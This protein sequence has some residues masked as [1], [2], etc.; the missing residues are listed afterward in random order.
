[1]EL[2]EDTGP[3]ARRNFGCL[4]AVA[5]LVF[6][7]SIWLLSEAN[8]WP[9]ALYFVSSLAIIAVV[10]SLFPDPISLLIGMV[11]SRESPW[12]GLREFEVHVDNSEE[13]PVVVMAANSK[14]AAARW[15]AKMSLSAPTLERRQH[16]RM[17]LVDGT[18][19]SFMLHFKRDGSF[20]TTPC[21]APRARP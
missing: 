16:I 4:V 8:G 20:E 19:R 7:G 14:Q 12:V 11:I 9:G 6:A 15:A 5:L 18:E 21:E 2:Y 17:K 1:M 10:W 13:P 3:G